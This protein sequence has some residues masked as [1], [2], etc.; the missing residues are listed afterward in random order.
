VIVSGAGVT[1]SDALPDVEPIAAVMDV[2]PTA[3][4]VATPAELIEATVGIEELHVAELVTFAEL[5]SE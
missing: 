1:V 4:A 3:S 2:A 5:P